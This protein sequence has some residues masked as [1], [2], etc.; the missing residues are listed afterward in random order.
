M[1]L[2]LVGALAI[3]LSG[4]LALPGPSVAGDGAVLRISA[5]GTDIAKL[6]PHRATS[7]TDKAA[8]DWIFNGLVRFAPGSAD[9]K[10]IEPDLAELVGLAALQT[11]GDERHHLG[12]H[13]RDGRVVVQELRHRRAS[14]GW[15]RRTVC[16]K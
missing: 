13:I 12:W 3:A 10:D 1:K 14:S 5:T 9:P 7:T 6:D 2:R 4:A 15:R 16:C 8:V 11:L